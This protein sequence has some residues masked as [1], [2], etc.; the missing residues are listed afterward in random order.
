MTSNIGAELLRKVGAIG[1]KAQEED[2]TY[3]DMKERLLGAAKKTFKPE[4][5]NRVDDI[6]VFRSLNKEDLK[7][8]VEIEVL[9]VQERLLEKNIELIIDN[10]AKKFIIEKGFDVVFGAR[11]LKRT[12]QRFLENPLAEE[13]LAGEYKDGSRIQITWEKKKDEL[14]FL[15]IKKESKTVKK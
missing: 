5:L 8:I 4:F 12:I 11:P 9:E 3:K 15:N 14:S 10:K 2:V 1:F 7:H 13:L 6:I